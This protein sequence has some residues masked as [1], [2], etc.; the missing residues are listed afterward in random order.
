MQDELLGL[1]QLEEDTLLSLE[2]MLR[3]SQ[4]IQSLMKINE[5][6]ELYWAK[7][8]HTKWLLEGESNTEFFHRVANGI[9][10]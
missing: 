2:Q 4:L 6:E 9:R 8:S 7:R 1:E 5:V 3:K 10:R